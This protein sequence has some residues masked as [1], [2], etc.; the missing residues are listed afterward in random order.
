MIVIAQG[1]WELFG[2]TMI[3]S[4]DSYDGAPCGARSKPL[5]RKQGR[6]AENSRQR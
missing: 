5:P 4:L 3:G 2:R 1:S 6:A